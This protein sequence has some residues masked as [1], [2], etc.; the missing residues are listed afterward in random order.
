MCDAVTRSELD[1]YFEDPAV[2]AA[3]IVMVCA[4][5]GSG[6]TA[7]MQDW[8]A[9]RG[10]TPHAHVVWLIATPAFDRDSTHWQATASALADVLHMPLP[11]AGIKPARFAA[12][13]VDALIAQATPAVLV[14]D[15]AHLL[16]NSMLLAAVEYLVRHAPPTVT[17]VLAGRSE[18]ALR[19]HSLDVQDRLSRVAPDELRLTRDQAAQV[20]QRHRCALSDADLDT[21]MTLTGGWAAPVAITAL[22]MAGTDRS[23]ALAELATPAQPVI[24]FLTGE[25]LRDMPWP[26]FE[27]LLRTAVPER[28]SA[29]LADALH[30]ER[31]HDLIEELTR[32]G[33]PLTRTSEGGRLWFG[34]PPLLRAFL[35]SEIRSRDEAELQ[36]LRVCATGWLSGAGLPDEALPLIARVADRRH[37]EQFVREHGL[38][39]I[40][41]G[42]GERLLAELDAVGAPS[43]DDPYLWRLRTIHSLTVGA[44][45]TATTY[46]NFARTQP[47]SRSSCVPPEWLEVLDHA[48]AADAAIA[49]GTGIAALDMPDTLAATGNPDIDCYVCVQS[50]TA[51]LLRGD[52]DRA[53]ELLRSGVALCE[54]F[55]R[56]RLAVQAMTRLAIGLGYR[57]GITAMRAYAER[58]IEFAGVHGILASPDV[59]RAHLAVALAGH[60]QGDTWDTGIVGLPAAPRSLPEPPGMPRDGLPTEVDWRVL[61]CVVADDKHAAVHQLRAGLVDLL[62]R[63]PMPA[64]GVGLL[65]R[66]TVGMLVRL[67]EFHTAE[68]LLTEAR[69]AL[70]ETPEV[71]VAQALITEAARKPRSTRALLEPFLRQPGHA[72]PATE[73]TAWLVYAAAVHRLGM[74][75]RTVEALEAALR[76]AEPERLL[77]PWLNHPAAI[78]LLDHYAGQFGRGDAFAEVVRHHPSALRTD[79]AP[80]L[81]ESEM[82]VLKHLPSGRTGTQIA[83]DLGVSI[84]TVKTHLRG[85]YGKLDARSR[86]EAIARARAVGLL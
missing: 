32:L 61:M 83:A 41:D 37:L 67:R 14:I 5:A 28:F 34:Y 20:F 57:G 86:V 44:D 39:L 15:D 29:E 18:P 30:G 74:P 12:H 1:H 81:T 45:G 59:T 68:G 2:S 79:A 4:P 43:A 62:R 84:N 19:W 77:L 69:T 23:T 10:G 6:K 85:L 9:R 82:I 66:S 49:A 36:R 26:A 63:R 8:L 24:D 80:A 78:E 60:I 47:N 56:D 71:V 33:I 55:A 64:L 16:T 54:H 35:L 58:A 21:V 27:F 73:L 72:H 38:G 22:R 52:F 7:L 76:L 50:G 48:I 51:M 13:L 11:P 65:V 17:I 75:A 42:H 70:G 3:R 31:A 53:V 25:V 46:L 40:L